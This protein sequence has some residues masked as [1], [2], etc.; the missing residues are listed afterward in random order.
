[1][2]VYDT[3]GTNIHTATELTRIVA[4]RP[5]LTYSVRESDYRGTYYRADASPTRSTSNPT[6]FP[7]TTA[8]TTS[9]TPATRTSKRSYS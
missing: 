9:T 4:D 2:T 3:Y 6:P 5:G 7:A 1:M 8:R